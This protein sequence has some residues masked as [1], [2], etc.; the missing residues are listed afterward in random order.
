MLELSCEKATV[1]KNEL[2]PSAPYCR[3]VRGVSIIEMFF[4]RETPVFP[5]AVAVCLTVDVFSVIHSN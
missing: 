2:R 5:M 4:I 1:G 3:D